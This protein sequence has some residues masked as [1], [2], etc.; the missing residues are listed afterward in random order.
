MVKICDHTS[1]GILVFNNEGEILLNERK[2]LPYAFAPPAGHLDG[3]EKLAGIKRELLEEDGIEV[4]KLKSV[5]E[6]KEFNPCRRKEGNWHLWHV[7]RAEKWQGKLKP[8]KDETKSK[9]GWYSQEELNNLALKTE[10]AAAKYKIKLSNLT[11][12]TKKLSEDKYWE[13]NPGL[14]P[15]WYKMLK[16]LR[17]I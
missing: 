15:V 1:V 17:V 12:L 5:L 3:D 7:F 11:L 14:E 10:I 16:I 9:T 13:E 4:L 6:S 8:S 2:R